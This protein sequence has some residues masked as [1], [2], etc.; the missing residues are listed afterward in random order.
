L[1]REPIIYS[2]TD[3]SALFR[4]GGDLFIQTENVILDMI[5]PGMCGGE[6]FDRL[7]D[8]NPH[9]KVLLS[10]GYSINGQAQEILDRGCNGF[11]KKPFNVKEI[12]RKVRDILDIVDP[13]PL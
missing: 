2:S 7:T 1:N 3:P 5:I 12:S 9:I 8:I 11:I 10:S 4:R 13:N 6:S